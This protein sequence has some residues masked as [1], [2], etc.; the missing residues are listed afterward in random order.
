MKLK[1]F[2]ISI[3]VLLSLV[4]YQQYSEYSSLKSINSYESCATAK[5]SIIQESYP[6]TCITRLGSR[7]TEPINK[8]LQSIS[9]TI[10]GQKYSF[11]FSLPANFEVKRNPY[12]NSYPLSEDLLITNSNSTLSSIT[13]I[14]FRALEGYRPT[15][16]RTTKISIG[17]NTFWYFTDSQY[18]N[19]IGLVK[20]MSEKGKE[21]I[22]DWDIYGTSDLDNPVVQTI[23]SSFKFT[24]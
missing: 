20:I 16:D 18:S 9:Q 15:Y 8:S 13:K 4:A 6:A 5:G 22:Y 21:M 23:L 14:E 11:S 17:Q 24:D 7:F 1:L 2:L 10:S 3:F 19:G 12:G